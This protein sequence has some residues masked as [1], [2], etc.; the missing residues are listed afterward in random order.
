MEAVFGHIPPRDV[1]L[2]KDCTWEV[3]PDPKF[4]PN[5]FPDKFLGVVHHAGEKRIKVT[6]RRTDYLYGWGQSISVRVKVGGKEAVVPVGPHSESEKTLLYDLDFDVEKADNIP[7]SIVQAYPN[8][9]LPGL[10]L[11]CT[12]QLLDLHPGCDYWLFAE[13]EMRDF[14]REHFPQH[15]NLYTSLARPFHRNQL[16]QALIQLARGSLYVECGVLIAGPLPPGRI[17]LKGHP[18]IMRVGEEEARKYSEEVIRGLGRKDPNPA[19]SALETLEPNLGIEDIGE[20]TE[21]DGS[22]LQG[23]GRYY[24]QE[25]LPGLYMAVGSPED[26]VKVLEASLERVVLERGSMDNILLSPGG[27]GAD[28]VLMGDDGKAV[29]TEEITLQEIVVFNLGQEFRRSRVCKLLEP[30]SL[31]GTKKVRLGEEV[32]LDIPSR[33]LIKTRDTGIS[34]YKGEGDIL[35]DV[36]V[37]SEPSLDGWDQIVHKVD[38]ATGVDLLLSL[39]EGHYLVHLHGDNSYPMLEDF[40]DDI[41]RVLDM[42]FVRKDLVGLLGGVTHNQEKYPT[43]LDRPVQA[44]KPDLMLD[45][46]ES[47]V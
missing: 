13:E 26:K 31:P 39:R 34:F 6:V 29:D 42:T 27:Y 4:P 45:F 3:L 37:E 17:V 9:R 47:A 19:A 8:Y 11:N 30:V 44:E 41:P 32:L 7:G 23:R 38:L 25:I 2:V 15:L 18:E 36:R 40:G 1:N 43:Y 46:L 22:S 21:P 16:F 20:V 24:R 28:H 12:K 35:S 10:L 33:V 5:A 14:V